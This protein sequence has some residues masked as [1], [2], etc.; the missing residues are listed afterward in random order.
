MN[1][2]IRLYV[3]QNPT[4]KKNLQKYA[5]LAYNESETQEFTVFWE[6][7]ANGVDWNNPSNI[8][9]AQGKDFLEDNKSSIKTRYEVNFMFFKPKEELKSGKP[10]KKLFFEYPEYDESSFCSQ[11]ADEDG[12]KYNIFWKSCIEGPEWIKREDGTDCT[13]EDWELVYDE[14]LYEYNKL[15]RTH[16]YI[17][18]N[19]VNGWVTVIGTEKFLPVAMK[20]MHKDFDKAPKENTR[21]L[22][23]NFGK[24]ILCVN[25]KTGDKTEWNVI[26]LFPYFMSKENN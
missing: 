17:I 7:S 20:V 4:Y 9:N 6:V 11:G 3:K 19:S 2:L 1:L 25:E 21:S 5:A 26:D 24:N 10:R 14:K 23:A 16:R 22:T 13:N 8:I 12:N 18:T 15:G